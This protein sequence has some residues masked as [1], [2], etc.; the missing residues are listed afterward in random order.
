MNTKHL[1]QDPVFQKYCTQD[2][3]EYSDTFD[4]GTNIKDCFILSAAAIC[5]NGVD[6][7]LDGYSWAIFARITNNVLEVK[8]VKVAH[9]EHVRL[10]EQH[11]TARQFGLFTGHLPWWRKFFLGRIPQLLVTGRAVERQTA[12]QPIYY[13]TLSQV[14]FCSAYTYPSYTIN[15]EEKL[16]PQPVQPYI[17]NR[18]PEEHYTC[19]H[20]H[21]DYKRKQVLT[22]SFF[23][24]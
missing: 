3:E 23:T 8:T 21:Y 14:S 5:N 1:P 13:P 7:L 20:P 12:H 2:V 4:L 17:R 9:D 19:M 18:I 15:W 6:H 24:F 22:Y 10:R 16:L 11:G